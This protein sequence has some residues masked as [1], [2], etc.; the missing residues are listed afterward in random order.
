MNAFARRGFAIVLAAAA[1]L[2]QWTGTAQAQNLGTF[3][4]QLQPYCNVITM[5]IT[6]EGATYRLA[7]WDDACGAVQRYPMSGTITA[8]SNGTLAFGFEVTRTNGIAVDTTFTFTPAPPYSGPWS[9]SAGNS[10][11]F[12]FG[13]AATG[14]PARPGPSSTLLA[15]SVTT[16]TIADSA[17]TTAK[18]LDGSVGL[19]DVNSAQVQLRVGGACGVGQFIRSVNANGTVVC[20]SAPVTLTDE[21]SGLFNGLT[22]T[23]E[24]LAALNFGTVGAG[25]LTCSGTVHALMDHA[26]SAA[27]ILYFDVATAAISC[28][29]A[30]RSTFEVPQAWPAMT[31]HVVTVPFV[32]SFAVTPGGLQVYLNA[33]TLNNPVANHIAHSISCTFTPQ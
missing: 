26:A 5:T 17:V 12:V 30:N 32:R 2:A 27:S 28:G 9:D 23:C 3:T 20:G 31:G 15:G 25:T 10:G 19:D 13:G 33:Q 29:G 7:G 22:S 11:T 1:L 4:F 14:N 8:N 16:G 6:Q 24:D 21:Q 18:I